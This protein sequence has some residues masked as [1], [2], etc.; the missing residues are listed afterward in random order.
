MREYNKLGNNASHGCVRVC[1]ADAKW[2]Y[3]QADKIMVLITDEEETLPLSSPLLLPPI[4]VNGN[5]GIDPTDV[6]V[7]P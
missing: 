2:I 3:E 6:E 7:N 4:I 1:V 5:K